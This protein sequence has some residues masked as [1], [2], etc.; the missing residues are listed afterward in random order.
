[1][2]AFAPGEVA[3]GDLDEDGRADLLLGGAAGLSWARGGKD[4]LAAPQR[5]DADG[6]G[7][8]L[9][10][11]LDLDGHVDVLQG[12]GQ[13][14]ARRGPLTGRSAAPAARL[15]FPGGA[16]LAAADMD[17]D[18]DL[19][20]VTLDAGQARVH[21]SG[22]QGAHALTVTLAGRKDNTYGV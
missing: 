15:L 12:G 4:G 19:D 1:P 8:L 13:V 2:G 3:A 6:G 9:L 5:I 17:G 11:D 20:L 16:A 14:R 7:P 10:A 21:V 22:L 18:G